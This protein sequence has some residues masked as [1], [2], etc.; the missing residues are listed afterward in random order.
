M[1]KNFSQYKPEQ[2]KW[3]GFGESGAESKIKYN[4]NKENIWKVYKRCLRTSQ[5]R[6][7]ILT[8]VPESSRVC[9]PM[10]VATKWP[11]EDFDV[12]APWALKLQ[13]PTGPVLFLLSALLFVHTLR[14]MYARITE[15]EGQLCWEKETSHKDRPGRMC[16]NSPRAPSKR[17]LILS[18]GSCVWYLV[19]HA[20]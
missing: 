18:K 1:P 10:T 7:K 8:K 13:A 2:S 12:Q 6:V 14:P 17:K 9:S 20:H 11:A 3:A 19:T 16:R 5:G 4:K 15:R